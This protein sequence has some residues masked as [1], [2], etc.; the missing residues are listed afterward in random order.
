M[1]DYYEI[2]GL[3]RFSTDD[4]IKRAYRM[5]VKK[6]H[7]DRCKNKTQAQQK[8]TEINKAY[9]VLG[10]KAKKQVYDQELETKLFMQQGEYSDQ[11]SDSD[12]ECSIKNMH[13]FKKRLRELN[14]TIAKTG[15]ADKIDTDFDS[16]SE[17]GV[18]SEKSS[19]DGKDRVREFLR[20]GYSAETMIEVTLEEVYTGTIKQARVLR[21]MSYYH[22]KEDI[23]DVDVRINIDDGD[24]VN[25]PNGGH[26]ITFR[27]EMTDKPGDAIVYVSVKRHPIYARKFFDLHTVMEVTLDEAKSGFTKIL[28]GIDGSDIK[29]KV[30]PFDRTDIIHVVRGRGMRRYGFDDGYGDVYINFVVTLNEKGREMKKNT[31]IFQTDDE[32]DKNDVPKKEKVKK[33]PKKEAPK[34]R[35]TK[36]VISESDNEEVLTESNKVVPVKKSRIS[37]KITSDTKKENEKEK[38]INKISKKTNKKIL[39]D[40]DSDVEVS[41]NDIKKPVKKLTKYSKKK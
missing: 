18:P 30:K 41:D 31:E 7:P 4:Q 11:I 10:N 8:I 21:R 13:D 25:V 37:K 22:T 28:K 15:I 24:T 35:A 5:M 12:S 40:N 39:S 23:I 36:K 27:N 20:K 38:P 1:A 34:K 29:V 33:A 16:S 26:Y 9:E 3:D 32:L 19:M 2:M 17:K 6:W 14:E